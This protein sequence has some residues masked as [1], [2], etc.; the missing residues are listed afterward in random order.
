MEIKVKVGSQLKER[1][2]SES[3]KLIGKNKNAK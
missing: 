1:K 2:G 3:V